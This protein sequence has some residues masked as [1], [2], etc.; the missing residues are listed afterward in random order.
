MLRA[1]LKPT[2]SQ[3]TADDE[4][5]LATLSICFL[6][7]RSGS[8]ALPGVCVVTAE[9]SHSHSSGLANFQFNTGIRK[10]R[11]KALA[12]VPRMLSAFVT[13]LLMPQKT[14]AA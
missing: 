10:V 9:Q 1:P 2:R 13:I 11:R 4:L 6:P 12:A 3:S 5:T 8:V 14:V 7:L